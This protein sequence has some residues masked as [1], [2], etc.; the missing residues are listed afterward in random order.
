MIKKVVTAGYAHKSN[1][2]E[3]MEKMVPEEKWE[4][5]EKFIFLAVKAFSFDVIKYDRGNITLITSPD[6]DSANEPL[7]GTC[8]RWKDGEWFDKG[9]IS[10]NYKETNNFRQI[11]HNKWQFVSSD[12]AGFDIEMAKERTKIWNNIPNLD[13]K[14]IGNKNY[15]KNLLEENG[16]T[17]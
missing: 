17:L 6:W 11:Y 10:M 14:R 16:I 12:Y 7:V 1:I 5:F 2:K 8:R 9:R 13:K 4:E 15:W 3:L